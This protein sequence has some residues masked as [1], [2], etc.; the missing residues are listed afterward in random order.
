MRALERHHQGGGLTSLAAGADTEIEV[1]PGQLEIAEEDRRQRIV[2]VLTGVDETL[3]DAPRPEVGDDRGRLH[4]VRPGADDVDD[5]RTVGHRPTS[6]V[7]SPR[8][9]TSWD[10]QL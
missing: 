4:E 2:V 7:Y 8:R 3:L 1:G 10:S 9:T 6:P 5:R